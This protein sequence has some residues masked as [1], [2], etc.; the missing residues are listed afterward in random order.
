[1]R[2]WCGAARQAQLYLAPI[3]LALVSRC[4]PAHARATAVG[5]WFVAGGVGGL[6]AGPVGALYSRWAPPAFFALL[7]GLSAAAALGMLCV[8]PRLQ[9]RAMTHAARALPRDEKRLVS[10]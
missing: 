3:G 1:M 7:A 2:V 10:V 8:A 9:R 5:F 4:C 6:L